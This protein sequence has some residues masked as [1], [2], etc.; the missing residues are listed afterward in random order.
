MIKKIL[1]MRIVADAQELERQLR[2][3]GEDFHADCILR[4]LKDLSWVSRDL[5]H[6]EAATDIVDAMYEPGGVSKRG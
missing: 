1:A 5:R 6:D 2:S 4:A 3:A